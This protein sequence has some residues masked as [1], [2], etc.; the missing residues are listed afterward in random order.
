MASEL[1]LAL[2]LGHPGVFRLEEVRL[3]GWHFPYFL[4]EKGMLKT[5]DER[6]KGQG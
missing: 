4:W 6:F 5:T 1:H 3:V 2:K